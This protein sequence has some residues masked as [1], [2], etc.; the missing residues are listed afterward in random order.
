MWNPRMYCLNYDKENYQCIRCMMDAVFK[1][2]N[3][4]KG[5][6]EKWNVIAAVKTAEVFMCITKA[7]MSMARD[8]QIAI[9]KQEWIGDYV[10][11]T[12]KEFG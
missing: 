2:K 4:Y 10:R 6:E 5:R 3:C 8:A 1:A 11:G 7:I 9:T 12:S